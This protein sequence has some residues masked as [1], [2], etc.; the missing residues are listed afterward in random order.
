MGIDLRRVTKASRAIASKRA[1]V[2][3]Q[4]GAL[5]RNERIVARVGGMDALTLGDELTLQQHRADVL[6]WCETHDVA[7]IADRLAELEKTLGVDGTAAARAGDLRGLPPVVIRQIC[8]H[9]LLSLALG[10]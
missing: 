9:A 7:A 8:E 2:D 10:D 3:E 6:A 1:H 5:R 4:I